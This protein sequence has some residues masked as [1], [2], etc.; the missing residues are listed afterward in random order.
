MA[1][2]IVEFKTFPKDVR[3]LNIAFNKVTKFL[4]YEGDQLIITPDIQLPDESVN[5]N[6]IESGAV[7]AS[8]VGPKAITDPKLRD[9]AGA[10]VIG[11]AAST[12]GQPG[13]IV[14]GS[15][16]QFLKRASGGLLFSALGDADIPS[17]IARDSEVTA[18][19]TAHEASPDP[20]PGYTTAAELAAAIS[21]L[22]A[23]SGTYTPTQTNVTNLDGSTAYVCQYL[24]VGTVVT[25]SGRLDANPTTISTLT[26]IGISLPFPSA[27]SATEQCAGNATSTLDDHAAIFADATNDRAIMSWIANDT[28]D[29]AMFFTFTYRII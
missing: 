29:H 21:A 23:V 5:E 8:K 6:E 1:K 18:A 28:T 24:R 9:S 15:D 26:Q 27:F 19:I 3:E 10:S 16:G 12:A 14:A 4:K 25:V 13:D 7:T 11:R 22:N 17:G 20:H 2:P